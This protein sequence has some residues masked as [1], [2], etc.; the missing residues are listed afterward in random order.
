MLR[1]PVAL[2]FGVVDV[3]SGV[4][5]CLG[6]SPGVVGRLGLSARLALVFPGF[7]VF[8]VILV[9]LLIALL[10]PF[11]LLELPPRAP[12]YLSAAPLRPASLKLKNR[13]KPFWGMPPPPPPPPPPLWGQKKNFKK[14]NTPPGG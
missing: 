8:P 10:A 2:V 9:A 13:L 1:R 5:G 12:R 6:A 11:G 7:A 4:L 3:A 14:K